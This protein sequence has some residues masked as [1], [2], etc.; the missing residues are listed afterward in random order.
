MN[1]THDAN[2]NN[3]KAEMATT[4][5]D[6]IFRYQLSDYNQLSEDT[7]DGLY[8]YMT[9]IYNS[10]IKS[11]IYDLYDD[12]E[13]RPYAIS[14]KYSIDFDKLADIYRGNTYKKQFNEVVQE[15]Y[16]RLKVA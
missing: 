3:E 6:C 8:N 9:N 13:Y 7:F 10:N 11:A 4:I 15:K 14:S 5:D 2:R 12:D 1:G 16:D